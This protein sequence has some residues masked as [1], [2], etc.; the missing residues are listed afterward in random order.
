[1]AKARLNPR[2]EKFAR[3]YVKT[4]NATKAYQKAGYRAKTKP[5]P[6]NTTSAATV[7]ASNLLTNP[8]VKNA[9][10]AHQLRTRTR[11][12]YTVD[13]ILGELD[14]ARDAALPMMPAAAVSATL[15]KARILGM[16]VD[17]KEVGQ[18]GDFGALDT[19]QAVL[20]L[21]AKELGQSVAA[22]L[23]AALTADSS[24]PTIDV[25]PEPNSDGE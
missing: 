17:R 4:G 1:M 21:I 22:A 7:N 11:H 15:G 3:E 6:G 2:Q 10:V 8:N 18:P 20:A 5:A 23:Q 24:P 13:T 14:E 9:I 16:I 19:T 12:D 25:T